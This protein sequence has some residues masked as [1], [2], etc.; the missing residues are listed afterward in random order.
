MQVKLYSIYDK[1]A[2]TYAPPFAYPY[3]GQAIRAF[4]DLV[5]D[6]RSSVNKHP[7]DYA[8]FFLGEYDD[9]TGE[10]ISLQKPEHLSEAQEY[11]L[12]QT[13]EA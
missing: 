2:Q 7:G 5:Q 3:H 13:P 12:K 10:L 9:N 6:Q 8:L 11:L 4:S 1:K